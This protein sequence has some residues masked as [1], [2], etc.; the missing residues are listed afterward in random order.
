[1]IYNT[2][3]IAKNTNT[4]IV[5]YVICI[6]V[7]TAYW[8]VT[9]YPF[10]WCSCRLT[11][12]QR[13]P[14]FIPFLVRFHVAQSF[15]FCVVFCRSLYTCTTVLFRLTIVLS[16]LRFTAYDYPFGILKLVSL[17]IE[18]N[19][20]KTPPFSLFI[21]LYFEDYF[22]FIY[23]LKFSFLKM[24]GIKFELHFHYSY[25]DTPLLHLLKIQIALTIWCLTPLSTILQLY[26]GSQFY[27]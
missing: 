27:W 1:L 24:W 20:L 25:Y 19:E 15:V 17:N 4:K 2:C 12:T 14:E 6:Y 23:K 11:V 10:G 8:C 22:T 26:S 5:I 21:L 18:Y 3:I 16:I 7:R 13:A 9:Q